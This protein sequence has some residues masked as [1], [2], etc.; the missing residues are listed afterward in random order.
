MSRCCL[1]PLVVTKTV[2]PS[3]VCHERCFD[4]EGR[5]FCC[6]TICAAGCSGTTG[7]DCVVS[8]KGGGGDGCGRVGVGEW[9]GED[10]T[11]FWC[12]P[13][14]WGVHPAL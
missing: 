14:C 1:L 3:T 8:V 5:K 4:F 13:K 9:R 7:S 6:N 10:G 11:A 2:C 12:G